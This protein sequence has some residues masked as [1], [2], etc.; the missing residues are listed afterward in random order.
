M[1]EEPIDLR[2]DD[3]LEF[4]NQWVY[5]EFTGEYDAEIF[6]YLQH[7]DAYSLGRDSTLYVT[8]WDWNDYY[9]EVGANVTLRIGFRAVFDPHKNEIVD[10]EIK[11]VNTDEDSF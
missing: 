10:F 2:I 3:V 1:D 11:E 7:T 6:G 4:M 8:D 5:L 9:V